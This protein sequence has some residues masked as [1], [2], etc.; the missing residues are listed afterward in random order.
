MLT[1]IIHN[2]DCYDSLCFFYGPRTVP[3]TLLSYLFVF[4]KV[5][6]LL[7]HKQNVTVP[8]MDYMLNECFLSK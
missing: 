4:L 6:Y 5:V 3:G 7:S 8:G 1:I 2:C